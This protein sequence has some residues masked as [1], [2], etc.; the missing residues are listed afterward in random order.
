MGIPS[1]WTH[2][3]TRVAFTSGPGCAHLFT[4]PADSSRAPE[5]F[6]EGLRTLIPT[7]WSPY[8]SAIAV[9]TT[10][11]PQTGIDV[12]IVSSGGK[13][14]IPLVATPFNE[15]AARFSPDGGWLAYVSNESGRDEVYLRPYP[16]PGAKVPV[17]RDG[18]TEPVWSKNGREL[19]Y[20]KDDQMLT[21]P[22]WI[23][24]NLTVGNPRLLFQ[25]QDTSYLLGAVPNANYDV[26]P[27]G[28]QFV[29]VQG[30]EPPAEPK[31]V[32]VLNWMEDLKRLV[33]SR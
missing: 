15:L 27:D 19:F 3:G 20:R 8:D 33:P 16:G 30:T 29:I 31:V 2:A 11:N 25:V 1:V 23:G 10:D 13:H 5:L 24:R 4:Q 7:S 32:L 6:F 9:Y 22:V 21:V 26:F 12:G 17:S 14:V 28:H 18:G